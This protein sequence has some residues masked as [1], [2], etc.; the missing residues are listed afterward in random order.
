MRSGRALSPFCARPCQG[1]T[2]ATGK[3]PSSGRRSEYP[4]DDFIGV[5]IKTAAMAEYNSL[6]LP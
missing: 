5:F 3:L 2:L 6:R 1:K 4:L